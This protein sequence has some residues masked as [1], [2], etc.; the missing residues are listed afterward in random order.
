MMIDSQKNPDVPSPFSWKGPRGNIVKDIVKSTIF[1]IWNNN[2][3]KR[4]I[5][6]I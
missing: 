6:G 1:V 5:S 3:K 4:T 2:Y